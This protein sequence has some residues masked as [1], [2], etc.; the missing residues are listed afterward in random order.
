MPTVPPTGKAEEKNE[1]RT[2]VP[3]GIPIVRVSPGTAKHPVEPTDTELGSTADSS[4]NDLA[5]N[6]LIRW[7]REKYRYGTANPKKSSQSMQPLTCVG[8][9]VLYPL[10]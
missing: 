4:G 7:I 1:Q 8:G 6:A 10:Q 5:A 2:A 3:E 9:F